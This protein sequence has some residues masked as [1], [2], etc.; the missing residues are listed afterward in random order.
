MIGEA[1]ADAAPL[2]ARPLNGEAGA[3]PARGAELI[4]FDDLESGSPM[5]EAAIDA[6]DAVH[7]E[8]PTVT[9]TET[10][11]AVPTVGGAVVLAS[12]GRSAP[13]PPLGSRNPRLVQVGALLIVAC[14]ALLPVVASALFSSF[15][16]G[17]SV[18]G[19][20]GALLWL[21][22]RASGAVL[23]DRGMSRS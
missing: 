16:R 17:G 19:V 15:A 11:A 5:Q 1:R 18:I 10:D 3:D 21:A 2:P 22:M 8:P 4:P 20:V 23:I 13:S 7:V 6:D 14:C 9:S 12:S